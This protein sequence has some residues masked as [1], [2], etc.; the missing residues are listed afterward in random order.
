MAKLCCHIHVGL[1]PVKSTF[2]A[3]HSFY[4]GTAE[5]LS[6][7]VLFARLLCNLCA[8]KAIWTAKSKNRLL[9]R[10]RVRP[11]LGKNGDNYMKYIDHM[12]YISYISR[13]NDV[14]KD[15][16]AYIIYISSVVWIHLGRLSSIKAL[17]NCSGV[18]G[19][20]RLSPES[21]DQKRDIA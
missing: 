12:I 7:D 4:C 3:L 21:V 11:K 20:S 1:Q 8:W 19:R 6:A 15:S 5:A 17:E 13:W 16:S 9:S 18:D 2:F 10:P 14:Y